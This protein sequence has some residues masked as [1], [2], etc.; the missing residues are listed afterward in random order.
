MMAQDFRE[1]AKIE[2]GT[3]DLNYCHLYNFFN[4]VCILKYILF[5]YLQQ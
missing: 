4:K 1:G 3:K 5:I 2:Y